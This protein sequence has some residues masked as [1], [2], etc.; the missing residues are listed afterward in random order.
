MTRVCFTASITVTKN[1]VRTLQLEIQSLSKNIAG[2][3]GSIRLEEAGLAETI[4]L[5]NETEKRTLVMAILSSDDL[6][7]MWGDMDA[8]YTLQDA[9]RENII[10]LSTQKE[11]L[12]ETKTATEQKRTALVKEQNKLVA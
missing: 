5:L 11:S 3:E 7:A 6:T 10:E 1:R 12:T 2:K 8:S 4:R 9:V